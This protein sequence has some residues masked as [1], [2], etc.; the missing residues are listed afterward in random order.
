MADY[1]TFV[2]LYRD[3][4]NFKSEGRLLLYGKFTTAADNELRA[5][6]C[7]WDYF[8]AEQ[9]D[10]PALYAELYKY[11]NGP[12]KDDI[13]YHEFCHLCVATPE[14]NFSY[15]LWG[16]LESLVTKFKSVRFWNCTLSPHCV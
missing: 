1:T 8:I 4:G 5:A 6:C 11:S 12:T 9:V 2:Y 16:N 14:D 7:D 13:A 15:P 3:A 10:V